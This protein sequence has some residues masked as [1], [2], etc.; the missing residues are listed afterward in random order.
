MGTIVERSIINS[1]PARVAAVIGA[2]AMGGVGS[3]FLPAASVAIA[4]IFASGIWLGVNVRSLTPR[5]SLHLRMCQH[6]MLL[7]WLC[8]QPGFTS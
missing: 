3:S 2:I 7:A 8:A 4:H 5:A 1:T 6:R